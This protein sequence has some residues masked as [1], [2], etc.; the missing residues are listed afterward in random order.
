MEMQRTMIIRLYP[1]RIQADRLTHFLNVGRQIF[2]RCLALKRRVWQDKQLNLTRFDLAKI[3]TL[4][5]SRED[6]LREVPSQ[7][8]RDA[9]RRIDLGFQHFFRRVK[10]KAAKVGYP[11]FKSAD[12]Y[13]SFSIGDPGN[14]VHK[15][16]IRVSGLTATIRCRNLRPVVGKVKQLRIVRRADRWFAQLVIETPDVTAE[17]RVVRNAVGMDMGLTSFVYGSDGLSVPAPKFYRKLEKKLRRASRN[18]SRKVKGSSNRRKAVRRLQRVHLKISDSRWNFTHHLSKQIVGK[19]DLIAVEKLNVKGMAK[20]RLSKSILDAAWGQ[21][22]WQ[23]EYKASSAGVPFLPV[24]PQWTSQDCSQCG[25]RVP[26]SLSVRTHICPHC[27]LTLDRDHNAAKN[28]LQ[29]AIDSLHPAP[30]RGSAK[31]AERLSSLCETGSLIKNKT[32]P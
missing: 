17:L 27:G 7:I 19:Y 14:V 29:R 22:L 6:S 8:E 18:V 23:L 13:N 3:L 9:I 16:K 12:R 4:W 30:V 28:I 25:Q 26:K 15:G 11:R 21:F 1:S 32:I 31:P 24:N 20:S 10:E 5:R 2:N